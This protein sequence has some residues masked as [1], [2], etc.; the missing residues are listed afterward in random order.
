MNLLID[1]VNNH[2][3][4]IN[5]ET[6]TSIH[7]FS[8]LIDHINRLVDKEKDKLL[9]KQLLN[10]VNELNID[11][12]YSEIDNCIHFSNIGKLHI[13]KSKITMI[14]YSHSDGICPMIVNMTVLKM[15]T[16]I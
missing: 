16:S 1:D 10:I 8:V 6:N 13:T 9:S 2:I 12:F 7:S 3:K 14:F 15:I 4:E 5:I 11:G